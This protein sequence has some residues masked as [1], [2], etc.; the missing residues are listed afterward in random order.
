MNCV[1]SKYKKINKLFPD[2]ILR[3]ICKDN[4]NTDV[5]NQSFNITIDKNNI[6]IS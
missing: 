5:N 6:V 1:S 3:L 2:E 4:N